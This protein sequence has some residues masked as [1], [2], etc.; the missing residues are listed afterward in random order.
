[1]KEPE[2]LAEAAEGLAE[3]FRLI[4]KPAVK[5]KVTLLGRDELGRVVIAVGFRGDQL[6]AAMQVE[7]FIVNNG[8]GIRHRSQ[9]KEGNTIL[10]YHMQP[11]E[12]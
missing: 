5:P 10:V 6:I 4:T 3:T 12:K 9:I 11:R 8:D 2:T 7:A 1:M